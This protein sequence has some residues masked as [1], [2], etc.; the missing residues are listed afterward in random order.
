MAITFNQTTF[1]PGNT[2]RVR[3]FHT[4]INRR[5]K[6]KLV[7]MGLLP[8]Q[9]FAVIRLAPFGNTIEIRIGDCALSVRS[10]ELASVD[11]EVDVS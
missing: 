8:D 5:Y 4:E 9:Q 2:Y 3:G 11:C 10:H 1:I 7:S 6:Q